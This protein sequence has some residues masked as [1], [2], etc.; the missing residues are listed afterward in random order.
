MR[1]AVFHEMANRIDLRR[2]RAGSGGFSPCG[3]D[4]IARQGRQRFGTAA[5]AREENA[6]TDDNTTAGPPKRVIG[7]VK[8]Q[9]PRIGE[10]RKA[11]DRRGTDRDVSARVLLIGSS[12]WSNASCVE[13][14][15]EPQGEW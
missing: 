1:F 12:Y 15:N 2:Y 10:S 8:R 13:T 11:F 9:T 4:S 14:C 3:F 5:L 7:V 6:L